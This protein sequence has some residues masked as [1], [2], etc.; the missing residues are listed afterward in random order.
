V[1]G[2]GLV[3]VEFAQFF[4]R[5]GTKVTM[6]QRGAT[7]LSDM[8]PDVGGA[9]ASAFTADGIE[10]LTG[11]SLSRVTTSASNKTVHFRQHGVSHTRSADVIL[12][13][14]GRRPNLRGLNVEAA[15]V[16]VVDG[17]LTVGADMRTSQPHIFA[18][19]DV[20]DLTPIVHLAIQ[21][22]ETAAFNATHP[23]V[24]ARV[25]DH[26]LDS[27]MVFTDPQVAIAGLTERQC[28]EQ[29]IPYLT[30]SYPFADHGK[31]M[32]LGALEGFVKLL[33]RPDNGELIGAQIVGPEAAELIHELI[34]VMYFHGTAQDLL[35]IP[36][37]HPTLAEIVTYPAESILEQ[38]GRS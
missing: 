29:A 12:H 34:A 21:Q 5:I 3:A 22:G 2:G 32:C 4:S 14:L 16:K 15:G 30:A 28:H 35:R 27:E 31:A 8:D 38:M 37:Y 19:G 26:R 17:R 7:L 6:L 25:I 13:A 20:N 23:D 9:L 36:H 24:P 10:V 1:L 11:V 33:C 18:V